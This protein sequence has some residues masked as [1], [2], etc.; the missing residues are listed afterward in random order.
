MAVP[1]AE[2]SISRLTVQRSGPPLAAFPRPAGTAQGPAGHAAWAMTTGGRVGAALPPFGS[3]VTSTWSTP[4]TPP[5]T[6]TVAVPS[7]TSNSAFVG[8]RR[9]PAGTL[10][11]HLVDAPARRRRDVADVERRAVAGDG[12]A[13]PAPRGPRARRP[14]PGRC[15]RRAAADSERRRRRCRA[16]AARAANAAGTGQ[17]PQAAP[18]AVARLRRRGAA[19]ARL[20][21]GSRATPS[22][23]GPAAWSS[24]ASARTAA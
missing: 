10:E 1:A 20:R 17:R 5:G 16:R 24:S 23:S 15:A 22:A 11:P 21:G 19:A 8:S 6:S 2:A 3:A 12:R 14:A 18:P 9:G 4:L 13:R 7:R